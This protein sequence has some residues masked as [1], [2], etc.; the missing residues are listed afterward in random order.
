VVIFFIAVDPSGYRIVNW[1]AV[2]DTAALPSRTFAVMLTVAFRLNVAPDA[3]S[4]TVSN[5]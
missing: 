4:E 1:T 3:V 2:P 5:G